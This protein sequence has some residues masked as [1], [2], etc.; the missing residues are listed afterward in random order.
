MQVDWSA[1]PP[2]GG[3]SII[4][5]FNLQL[6]PLRLQI[7]RRT[8]RRIMAYVF[9]R[10]E[11]DTVGQTESIDDSTRESS[12]ATAHRNS[13]DSSH[14]PS[15]TG[16][17]VPAKRHLMIRSTS[18]QNLR[19]S[20][21]HTSQPSR[22]LRKTPSSDHLRLKGQRTEISRAH[23]IVKAVDADIEEMRA[24][25]NRNRTFLRISVSR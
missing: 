24:R 9:A 25:S 23:D 3:I 8:G 17:E 6:H 12:T 15:S 13:M 10:S 1:L 5:S 21:A 20:S 11:P 14:L 4:E 7:E 16:S 18:Q 2:V 22:K 19:T